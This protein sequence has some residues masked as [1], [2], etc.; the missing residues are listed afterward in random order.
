[1]FDPTYFSGPEKRNYYGREF[2]G[3]GVK[4]IDYKPLINSW[5]P[6]DLKFYNELLRVSKNQIIWGINYFNE[7]N[8]LVGPGRIIWDKKNEQSDF[9]DCEIASCSS[10]KSVRKFT[11]MWC[12][13]MR[14]KSLKEGHIMQGNKEKNIKR[15]HP[16]E[17]PIELYQYCLQAYAKPNDKILDTH[18]GSQSSRIA[19]FK[20]D[21]DFWGCE[22]DPDYFREGCERFE[23]ECHDT[24]ITKQGIKIIQ[25]TIF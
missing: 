9:S 17:K 6:A 14:G 23:R 20:L 2:S 25:G 15:I 11:F 10:M 24:I 5:E 7:F 8:N 3:H 16:T 18:L 12:G 22:L 1:V 4:R 21:F 13:M 19:A